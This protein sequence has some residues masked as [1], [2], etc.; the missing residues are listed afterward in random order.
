MDIVGPAYH[1]ARA[2]CQCDQASMP[3]QS[4]APKPSLTMSVQQASAETSHGFAMGALGGVSCT[5][6]P[7]CLCGKL[8]H[9][10]DDVSDRWCDTSPIGFMIAGCSCVS[11]SI[12]LVASCECGGYIRLRYG[13][14][15]VSC[16]TTGRIRKVSTRD[17]QIIR[18]DREIVKFM[19][20]SETQFHGEEFIVRAYLGHC[21]PLRVRYEDASSP[22]DCLRCSFPLFPASF[23]IS[24]VLAQLAPPPPKVWKLERPSV[25]RCFCCRASF[26]HV[27]RRLSTARQQVGT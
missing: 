8:G 10:F 20:L 27:C 23:S 21:A 1:V 3:H 4:P 12:V 6:T 9:L 18:L 7:E 2:F 14:L 24:S 15:V 26:L 19:R 16:L 11:S 13:C 5:I 25:S 22:N 17:S